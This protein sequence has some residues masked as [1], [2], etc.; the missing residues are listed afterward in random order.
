MPEI[1]DNK[2]E[3]LQQP[4]H[5]HDDDDDVQMFLILPSIGM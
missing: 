4:E 5:D 2:P 1:P 3:G